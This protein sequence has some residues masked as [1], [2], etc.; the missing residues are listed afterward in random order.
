MVLEFFLRILLN[1]GRLKLLG[2]ALSVRG[3]GLRSLMSLESLTSLGCSELLCSRLSKVLS[4]CRL[5]SSVR[6][7]YVL[8]L[9]SLVSFDRAMSSNKITEFEK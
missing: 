5:A 4:R 6:S 8:V 7:F 1:F 9:P 3:L 2:A